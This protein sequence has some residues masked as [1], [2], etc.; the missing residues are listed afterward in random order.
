MPLS[1]KT[2]WE[3]AQIH[4]GVSQETGQVPIHLGVSGFEG[5]PESSLFLLF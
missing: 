4:E 1:R 2:G 5:G 3:G